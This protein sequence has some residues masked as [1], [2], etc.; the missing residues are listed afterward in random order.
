MEITQNLTA[1]NGSRIT[2]TVK[3][4]DDNEAEASFKE[5]M[6]QLGAGYYGIPFWG[7]DVKRR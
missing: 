5:I 1:S 2:I 7:G 3:D 6:R 4:S